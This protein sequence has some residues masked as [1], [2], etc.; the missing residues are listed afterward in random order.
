MRMRSLFRHKPRSFILIIILLI[1]AFCLSGCLILIPYSSNI[2]FPTDNEALYCFLDQATGESYIYRIN[3]STGANEL[4]AM[5]TCPILGLSLSDDKKTLFYFEAFGTNEVESD[6][7]DDILLLKMLPLDDLK[8]LDK[9]KTIGSF[10]FDGE[11]AKAGSTGGIHT[12]LPLL[13]KGIVF[14]S[15][16]KEEFVV[17]A[18]VNIE[19]GEVNKIDEG[20]ITYPQLSPNKKFLAYIKSNEIKGENN[21]NTDKYNSSINVL[22]LNRM[23]KVEE[24]YLGI[25]EFPPRFAFD[26]RSK[27]RYKIYYPSKDKELKKDNNTYKGITYINSGENHLLIGSYSENDICV[28][29]LTDLN[30]NITRILNFGRIALVPITW[31]PDGRFFLLGSD[32]YF[33][34][35]FV[36]EDIFRVLQFITPDGDNAKPQIYSAVFHELPNEAHFD[37][38]NK[39]VI[40]ND[41][42]P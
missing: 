22:D 16:V 32:E 26:S 37:L 39:M 9:A 7:V 29:L 11:I 40:G 17:L 4:M 24:K 27:D 14:V 23:K 31:S 8:N 35:Y 15:Y 5:L 42:K 30:C 6:K 18:K 3:L 21:A 25:W 13:D 38:D 33:I 36:N 34:Q 10:R 2:V 28:P 1:T 19:S 20:I 41:T 12:T